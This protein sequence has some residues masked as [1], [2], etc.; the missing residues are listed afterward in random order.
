MHNLYDGIQRKIR[1][2]LLL[3]KIK[4]NE[5]TEFLQNVSDI[6]HGNEKIHLKIHEIDQNELLIET[7]DNE[8]SR[9]NS[10][11]FRYQYSTP[12]L[13]LNQ[14]KKSIFNNGNTIT[15]SKMS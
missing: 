7:Q 2:R 5:Q 9:L 8:M 13:E 11:I 10:I 14:R 3:L 15:Y 12:C 4:T 6:L 1:K